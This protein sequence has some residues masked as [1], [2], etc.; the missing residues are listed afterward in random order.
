MSL[1]K[2]LSHGLSL[3]HQQASW[4][5]RYWSGVHGG[6][7]GMALE[8]V[9]QGCASDLFSFEIDL[10]VFWS[11]GTGK[12]WGEI[13]KY[14][15]KI[16]KAWSSSANVELWSQAS[17]LLTWSVWGLSSGNNARGP[18]RPFVI[19]IRWADELID[20]VIT[21]NNSI[22]NNNDTVD[23]RQLLLGCNVDNNGKNENADD[24]EFTSC[25]IS[26]VGRVRWFKEGAIY[27]NNI[28]SVDLK[29]IDNI[30]Q[31]YFAIGRSWGWCQWIVWAFK[32]YNFIYEW[33]WSVC[34]GWLVHQLMTL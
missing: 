16:G 31:Y 29:W 32:R 22:L 1:I 28:N 2:C 11:Q 18:H 3:G 4:L 14:R 10:V 17:T 12:G 25:L 20:N 21:T 7:L 30:I 5:I 6:T 33:C 8:Q 34:G 26:I 24:I 9:L 27:L 13:E 15:I 19:M 23:N